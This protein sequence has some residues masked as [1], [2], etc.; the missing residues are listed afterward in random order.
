MEITHVDMIEVLAQVPLFAELSPYELKRYVGLF[1]PI[2]LYP[3]DIVFAIGDQPEAAY[4]IFEGQIDISIDEHESSIPFA[5]MKRGDLFGEEALLFDDPR[6]YSATTVD[7]TILLRLDVNNFMLM[8]ESL[9]NAESLL[10]VSISSRR[11]AN[12][13]LLPWLHGDEYVHVITRRH[14]AILF[15]MLFLP[16]L[17]VISSVLL[18]ALL[19]L[20]W[21]PGKI[22]GWLLF[23]IGLPLSLLWLI[24]S[25]VDWRNDYFIVTNKRVVWTEK[26]AF[27]YESRQEAP[28]RTIMSVGVN[29]SRLGS[30]L[31]FGDVVVTTYVGTILLR[32]IANAETTA[33]LVEA[34]WKQ[35]DLIDRHK[36]AQLMDK[37]LQEKLNL[38]DDGFGETVSSGEAMQLQKQAPTARAKEP[39]F[40]TWLL[41]D[42]IR[43]R[44][45]QD[46]AITYRK[47][48][49]ILLRHLWL[50]V[51]LM[52]GVFIVGLYRLSGKLII[53]PLTATLVGIILLMLA[54][55]LWTLYVFEDWRN[56]VF[57]VSLD[58]V[59]DLD[60]K[61]L[62]KTRR[63]SAPLENILSIEY[64]RRGIWGYLFNFGTV[65]IDVGATKLSF[66]HV[67]HPSKVQEDI[68]YRMGERLE[69]KRQ[70]EIDAERERISEW[71]ASYHRRKEG[72]HQTKPNQRRREN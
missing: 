36:E 8:L 56:D 15:S 21:L 45:E 42:F 13:V 31:G 22:F 54:L 25:Y 67:Y 48:W 12:E 41:S 43:L 63:R 5:R 65:Y 66:D 18:S 38:P 14:P 60:R 46:G 16:S 19:A 1:Q 27:V 23:L 17:A 34:Y 3:G 35:S 11:M 29:R 44:Y 28:M 47:H 71:I 24:W 10:D 2:A 40:L 52:I 64:E 51:I 4:V 30:L 68:F 70:F 58:Q 57:M 6:G 61:P 39:G 62:G 26:V 69:Q 7:E 32:E 37:K 55:F 33:K 53:L 72:T 50:P 9:P 20:I 49:F 59:V